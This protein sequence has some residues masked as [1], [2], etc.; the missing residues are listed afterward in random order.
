MTCFV[1]FQPKIEGVYFVW[2]LMLTLFVLCWCY[3]MRGSCLLDMASKAP[4]SR[5][6]PTYSKTKAQKQK[7]TANVA[8]AS[9][10]AFVSIPTTSPG[11]GFRFQK[12]SARNAF[13]DCRFH[14]LTIIAEWA[15]NLSDLQ[16]E[17]FQVI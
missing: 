4:T 11:I 1:L 5:K 16:D 8:S 12:K 15:I 2:N 3:G 7:A 14:D 9:A 10:F 13:W 6:L 17:K